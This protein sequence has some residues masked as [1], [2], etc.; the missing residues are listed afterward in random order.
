V[1]QAAL[2]KTETI[3]LSADAEEAPNPKKKKE[4]KD[5]DAQDSDR[6]RHSL[7]MAE[8]LAQGEQEI[9]GEGSPDGVVGGTATSAEDGDPYMTKLADIWDRNWDLPSIIPESE[10]RGL[11]VL[12]VL[13]IDKN[14]NIKFPLSFD[15][16]SGNNHFD[17][18]I[19]AAW[20]RI[21]QI[22]LP[23]NDRYASILANGLPLKLT[24]K[25]LQ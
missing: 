25:G 9:E 11:Y 7:N 2:R 19:R 15:R 18:S 21:Q 10:A 6:I 22:P 23:P 16:S 4:E 5:R 12:I 1:P 24:Y 8:V 20:Q 13:Q 17:N 3:D 14:G